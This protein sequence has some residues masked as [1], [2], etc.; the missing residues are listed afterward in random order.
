VLSAVVWGLIQGLTEFIPVSSSGHL[1]II[2]ALLAEIGL[3]VVPPSLAVSV[4]L[5]LG[6]LLAVLVYFRSDLARVVRFR[7][8]P[9][10]RRI[11][12]LVVV[13]TLPVVVGLPLEDSVER[14]QETVSNVGWALIGTGVILTIGHRLA[15]GTRELRQGRVPDAVAVGLAQVLAL[16]PGISRSGTTITAGNA[17]RFRPSEAA[18]YS[19]LLGIPAIAGAGIVEIP[20][21]VGTTE[22]GWELVV[23]FAVAAITGYLAIA[24]LLGVINK[25]GL[26]PFAI[27]CFAVGALTL[28]VFL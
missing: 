12:M 22:W 6:T 24:W 2:P 3:E 27:Y 7:S 11:L 21:M 5:H 4:F 1:V 13:G 10:G 20:D 14:F 26:L 25:I 18:R 15:N 28:V 23:G 8:D 9:E 19:F 16:I 17:R